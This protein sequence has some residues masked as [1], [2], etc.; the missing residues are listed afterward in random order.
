MAR[1]GRTTKNTRDERRARQAA[2]HARDWMPAFLDAFRDLGTVTAACEAAGVARRTVY[3]ARHADEDFAL[4]WADVETESTESM[5]LEARRRAVKG[6][7]KPV[8]QG[9]IEVGRIREYSDTLLIFMLKAR[10]PETYR[11]NV[12]IEHGGRVKLEQMTQLSDQELQRLAAG[13][14]S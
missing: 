6:T 13:D 3:D 10:R 4:A 11:D 9:G 12:K 5:E 8:F 14:E 1:T 2:N 7:D